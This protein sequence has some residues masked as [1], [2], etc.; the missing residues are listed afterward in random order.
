MCN[1]ESVRLVNGPNDYTGRIEVFVNGQWGTVCDDGWDIND[2]HVICRQLG[3]LGAR[4]KY[5]CAQYGQG[6]G[7]ML[8]LGCQGSEASFHECS[9]S[10]TLSG[11]SHNEDAGVECY[12]DTGVYRG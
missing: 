12:N 11:C 9:Q 2:A 6:T 3:Y 1:T 10:V 7:P 8:R 5:C 4:T